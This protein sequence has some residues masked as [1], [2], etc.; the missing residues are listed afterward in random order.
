MVRMGRGLL[1]LALVH[2]PLRKTGVSR[3]QHRAMWL[4]ISFTLSTSV[5]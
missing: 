2:R 1:S 3:E 5:L 4:R